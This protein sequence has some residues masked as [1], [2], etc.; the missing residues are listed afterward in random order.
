MA[1]VG[2]ATVGTT[3]DRTPP[4]R[5]RGAGAGSGFVVYAEREGNPVARDVDVDDLDTDDVPRLDHVPRVP[6]ERSGHRG[7]VH[8]PVLVYAHV[9]EGA[10]VC[11]KEL[12]EFLGDKV[13]R[14]CLPERW[15]FID[16]VPL[17]SVGKFDKKTIRARYAENAYDVIEQCD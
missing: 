11:A 14:W 17:T 7:H 3:L 10:E 1:T 13:V 15:A 4:L 5:R 8:E 16:Q 9:N 12:R 2:L 6:H